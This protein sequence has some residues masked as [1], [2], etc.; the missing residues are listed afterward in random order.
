M[1]TSFPKFLLII[2]M[3]SFV[4]CGQKNTDKNE[5]KNRIAHKSDPIRVKNLD[6]KKVTSNTFIKGKVHN[7]IT[8]TVY[9]TTLPYYSPYRNQ[10][11]YQ[12]LTK[13]S[14]FLF[15]FQNI[16][17][18]IIIQLT[19]T[20]PA[21][22]RNIN[23]LLF[24]NLTEKYY[25]GQCAKFN[26]YELTT[27][28]LEPGD[29]ILVDLSFNSWIENLSDEKAKYLKSLGVNVQDDNTVRDYGKT[30]ISFLNK[31]KSSLEYYQKWFAIDDEFDSEIELSEDVE[32]AFI[33]VKK[34]KGKFIS[35][36]NK[37]KSKITP[38]LYNHLMAYI[39]FG[40]KKEFLKNLLF[41]NKDYL[42]GQVKNEINSFLEFDKSN[43]DFAILSSDQYN[44]YIELYLTYKMNKKTKNSF[45]YYPFNNEKYQL[46]MNELPEKSQY[47]YLANQLLDQVT[48]IENKNLSIQ[49]TDK[50]PKGELNELLKEKYQ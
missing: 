35:D 34:L 21:I 12:T 10:T 49:L 9:L 28:L 32:D 6:I 8:D 31:E 20:K 38:F 45:K 29:S 41:K 44:E 23:N 2:L 18:P 22:D 27:Y 50:F 14:T 30:K 33:S 3:I 42:N 15:D 5:S 11:Y 43:I 17:S 25:F 16:D 4:S 37:E 46:V 39:E 13:D 7:W 40:A 19:A 1:K 48:T 24:D 36:I 26:T 47:P